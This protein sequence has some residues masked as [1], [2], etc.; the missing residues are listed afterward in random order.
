MKSS[1][2]V[3]GES[4][5]YTPK[6]GDEHPLPYD[7]GVPPAPGTVLPA[8]L[9]KLLLLNYKQFTSKWHSVSLQYGVNNTVFSTANATL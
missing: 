4:L 3:F 6:L 7:L 9:G 2:T 5:I 8:T 1:G